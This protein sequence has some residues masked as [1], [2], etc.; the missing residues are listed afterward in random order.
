MLRVVVE[1]G[2]MP[3]AAIAVVNAGVAMVVI[4]FATEGGGDWHHQWLFE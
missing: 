1:F 4:V 3:T 2:M